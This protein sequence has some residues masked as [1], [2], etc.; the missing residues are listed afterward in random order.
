MVTLARQ[1]VSDGVPYEERPDKING[2]EVTVRQPAFAPHPHPSQNGRMVETRGITHVLLRNGDELFECDPCLK[3]F[4]SVL[5]TRGHLT[6]HN[7][8]K[9][10]SLYPEPVLRHIMR[11]VAQARADG[12][13]GYLQWTADRLNEDGK[14]STVQGQ[15]WTPG[16]IHH[17]Y[18]R[19]KDVYK[20]N[21][22]RTVDRK[23]RPATQR[24]ATVA[25]PARVT[26][27]NGKDPRIAIENLINRVQNGITELRDTA[28]RVG[29]DLADIRAHLAELPPAETAD[30][31]LLRKADAYDK[32]AAQ[33]K[34]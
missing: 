4:T 7:T 18:T 19:Y 33:L 29:H 20:V 8:G 1:R 12:V 13:R 11:L 23:V 26:R 27:R 16:A 15:P 14:I 30:P 2:I 3:T 22:R 25:S 21:V 9:G 32:I 5:S 17:L 24:V 31:E 34:I 6:S 28:E 10:Q